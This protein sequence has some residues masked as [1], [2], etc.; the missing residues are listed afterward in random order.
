MTEIHIGNKGT[1]VVIP[2]GRI[3][4]AM[5]RRRMHRLDMR[6]Y[7]RVLPLKT[8]DLE[9]EDKESVNPVAD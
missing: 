5:R 6:N 4:R 1:E 9:H 3:N 8:K 2:A 7:H